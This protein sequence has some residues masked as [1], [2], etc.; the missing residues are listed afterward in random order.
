MIEIGEKTG[1][2]EQNLVYLSNNYEEELDMEIERF[3]SL[4]EP[5]ILI[6]MAFIVG[7]MALSIVTPI[8]ELSNKI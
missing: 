1:N 4:L 6:I 2:L 8:Y 3:V 7:F 5:F